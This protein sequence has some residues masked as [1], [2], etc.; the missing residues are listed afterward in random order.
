[1]GKEVLDQ[2]MPLMDML[3]AEMGLARISSGNFVI[4]AVGAAM[5][6][7]ATAM[8]YEPLSL[9]G[10]MGFCPPLWASTDRGAG[11]R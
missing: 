2:V 3:G 7:L 11:R 1:M 9:V 4:I 8:R 6:G 5:I 10:M